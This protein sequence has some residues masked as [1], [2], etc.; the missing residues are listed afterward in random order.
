MCLLFF[1]KA[2]HTLWPPSTLVQTSL[3]N[4]EG[5]RRLLLAECSALSS[6]YVKDCHGFV[7]FYHVL[8]LFYFTFP[9]ILEAPAPTAVPG[10]SIMLCP[11]SFI[12]REVPLLFPIISLTHPPASKVSPG[13]PLGQAALA[14]RRTHVFLLRVQRTV[15]SYPLGRNIFPA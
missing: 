7:S 8:L 9:F 14:T 2:D 10:C 12:Q 6:V 5:S 4:C 13:C 3:S 15:C 11:V 1:G